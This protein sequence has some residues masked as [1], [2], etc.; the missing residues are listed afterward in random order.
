MDVTRKVSPNDVAG[1]LEVSL[2]NIGR[3]YADLYL[4]HWPEGDWLNYYEQIIG[5]Y[6]K[7]RC[8]AF[9]ACNLEMEHLKA[10]EDAGLELPMVMQTEMHPL[11]TRKKILNYCKAHGIQV[12]AHT[13]TGTRIREIQE[14][15]VIL[16]LAKKYHKTPTQIIL[17]WHYQNDV[18]PVVSTFSKNHMQENLDIFDFELTDGE[19][20][21]ID[22]MDQN[23][24]TLNSHGID[25]PN[26]IYNY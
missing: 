9:G 4:L 3:E 15:A 25:D 17:R 11:C 22:G 13:P 14:S 23:Y 5:E 21:E 19:M 18:I 16:N 20:A 2:K 7:G 24:V 10:I 8:R 6:K 26:Y 1:N 12:M